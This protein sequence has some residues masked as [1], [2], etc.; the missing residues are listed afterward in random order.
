MDK[1]ENKSSQPD[2]KK[3]L[4]ETS[5]DLY[6]L[7]LDVI[8]NTKLY[9]FKGNY[10]DELYE[11]ALKIEKAGGLEKFSISNYLK[12]GIKIEKIKFQ[13]TY[14]TQMGQELGVIG[15]F[16]EL[17][18]WNQDKALKMEWTNGNVWI[19]KI[20]YSENIDFEFKFIFIVN[21]KV[22]K[23]EDGNNR[24]FNFNEI[25]SKLENEKN[26]SDI[27]NINL[28]QQIYKFDSNEN[29]LTIIAEW[30]KK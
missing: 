10:F 23:W 24:I 2:E 5:S 7:P 29:L 15:S 30:N 9:N 8:K 1:K 25:K 11:E 13:M 3:V 16:K 20:D 6:K 21:M 27:V 4:I 28:N 19:K 18:E 14:Q 22:E 12:K 17:G 26:N